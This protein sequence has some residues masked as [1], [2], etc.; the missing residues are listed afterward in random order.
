M[1]ENELRTVV[2]TNIRR[3]R[4]YRQWTQAEFAEKLDISVNFLCDIENGKRWIS[5]SS[6]VK[7][8]CILNIEPFELFKPVDAPLP[9]VSTLFSKY[10]D[11]VVQAVS[12]SL[13]Q[14]YSYFQAH[15]AEECTVTE[16]PDGK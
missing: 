16:E 6:M 15:L 5:P 2:R 3:Y 13:K 14:V 7:I 9:T 8:A 12:A 10:N 4:G 1:T 11:E